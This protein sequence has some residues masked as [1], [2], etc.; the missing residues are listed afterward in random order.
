MINS[1]KQILLAQQQYGDLA[2]AMV[3]YDWTVDKKYLLGM[4]KMVS[5]GERIEEVQRLFQRYDRYKSVI[6]NIDIRLTSY[7]SLSEMVKV[8]AE[9]AV[10][11]P[12]SKIY[13]SDDGAIAISKIHSRDEIISFPKFK[14]WC[15]YKSQ[16]WWNYYYN[17]MCNSIYIIRNDYYGSSP[18]QICA[19]LVSDYGMPTEIW[20]MNNQAIKDSDRLNYLQ[21]I[22]QILMS[23]GIEITESKT[24]KNMKKNTIRLNENTLKQIVAES[25]KKVLKE[26]YYDPDF[27]G[28]NDTD[29]L[30]G[31]ILDFI[32]KNKEKY[33]NANRYEAVKQVLDSVT[34]RTY[35]GTEGDPDGGHTFGY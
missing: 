27:R 19:L 28:P 2:N 31:D 35:Y 34:P 4:C 3:Q 8:A 9:K 21:S 33:Q 10:P 12:G 11:I 22:K 32:D 18:R 13:V 23:C 5:E 17:T 15:I 29:R 1:D 16:E 26:G 14:K 30:A 6:G 7:E 25:V 20:D 24:N